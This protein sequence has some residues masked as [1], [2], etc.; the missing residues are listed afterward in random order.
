MSGTVELWFRRRFNLAPTDPR[1]LDA[2]PEEMLTEYWAHYY[3][4]RR[5]SG[6]PD[7][8]EFEDE[9]FDIER[10]LAENER[11]AE[12]GDDEWEEVIADGSG[13]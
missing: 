9:E 4:E 10:I 8:E 12:G 13:S 3:E 6:K 11:Q 5:L 2:T 1:Y 7:E